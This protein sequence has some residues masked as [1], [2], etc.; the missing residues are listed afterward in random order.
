MDTHFSCPASL[1][2][3][4]LAPMMKKTNGKRKNTRK[5]RQAERRQGMRG[6]KEEEEVEG[7]GETGEG[8]LV[9]VVGG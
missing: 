3:F 4:L 8:G 2:P 1:S 5:G 9:E 6:G 7:E